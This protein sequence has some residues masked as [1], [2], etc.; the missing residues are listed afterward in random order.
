MS[1]I[2]DVP[3]G[4]YIYLLQDSNHFMQHNGVYKIGKTTQKPYKRC[5]QYPTGSILFCIVIVDD[6]SLAEVTLLRLFHQKYQWE[7][8]IGNEYFRGD[9]VSMMNDILE[10]QRTHFTM[11]DLMRKS[12]ARKSLPDDDGL[13]V[14]K[15]IKKAPTVEQPV[16]ADSNDDDT[17]SSKV[18]TE[19]DVKAPE[20]IPEI[21]P[22]KRSMSVV[23][24]MME[25]EPSNKPAKIEAHASFAS[26]TSNTNKPV[27]NANGVTLLCRTRR[28]ASVVTRSTPKQN[29]TADVKPEV[30][31]N[32]DVKTFTDVKPTTDV[33][34]NADV[35]T[36]TESTPEVTVNV[37]E[38]KSDVKV[39][40]EVNVNATTIST[41]VAEQPAKPVLHDRKSKVPVSAKAYV[42]PNKRTNA[43]VN[44]DGKPTTTN[45]NV[46]TDVKPSTPSSTPTKRPAIKKNQPVKET[47]L[48]KAPVNNQKQNKRRCM[49]PT[50]INKIAGL[51]R[52][53]YPA[54][55]GITAEIDVEHTFGTDGAYI[56]EIRVYRDNIKIDTTHPR[57]DRRPISNVGY[58][59]LTNHQ[60]IKYWIPVVTEDQPHY[61]IHLMTISERTTHNVQYIKHYVTAAGDEGSN[62]DEL[63]DCEYDE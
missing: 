16:E 33:K 4:E 30:K 13:R 21:K 6:C 55:S 9:P 1:R 8:R 36:V 2:V 45:A 3:L 35:K 47:V 59:H 50:S 51:L 61:C 34:V 22:S 32:A 15:S 17:S 63:S 37:D 28:S 27:T 57:Q 19:S 44:T 25:S 49:V 29:V 26:D 38:P 18:E 43:N 56:N 53:E 58:I 41:P 39:N 7:S 23:K 52:Q 11:E 62:N 46:N 40:V 5:G 31:V 12:E 54:T 42:P 60:L 14:R 48:K 20:D 10:Y 24:S